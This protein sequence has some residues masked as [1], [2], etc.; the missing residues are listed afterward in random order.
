MSL[1]NRIIALQSHT[2]VWTV[3][4]FWCGLVIVAS[5]YLTIPLLAIFSETFHLSLTNVAW[6]GSSFSLCYAIG[7]LISGP[8]SDR[9]GRK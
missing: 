8:M 6:V 1:V 7:S 5:N 3:V 4:L 9:Y 2:S